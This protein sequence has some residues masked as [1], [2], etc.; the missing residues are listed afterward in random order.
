MSGT[1]SGAYELKHRGKIHRVSSFN[2]LKN[3]VS[4]SRVASEDSFRKAGSDQWISVMAEPEFALILNPENQWV[5]TM[6]S[7][8]FKTL[9]FETIVKWA[10]DGRITEDAVIEGP[11]TPPGGVSATALP[12]IASNLKKQIQN[13]QIRPVLRIDGK[14]HPAPDTETIRNWIKDSRVPVEAEIS[15]EGKAWEPVSSCGLFDLEDWPLAAHGRVVEKLLPEMPEPDEPALKEEKE[16]PEVEKKTPV[17]DQPFREILDVDAEDHSDDEKGEVP[18]IV[19][20]G[21]SEMAIES[22]AKI[23][24]LLR[25]RVIFSYDEVRHPSIAEERTSVGEFMESMM[26]S[27]RNP[28]FWI[29]WGLAGTA[30]IVAALEY[31]EVLDFFTWLP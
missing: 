22:V 19:I 13:K 6:K 28:M 18:Y 9:D 21:D 14:K 27:R 24:S 11:R 30:V 20:S 15:L 4:E 16:Q 23:K 12:A 29:L 17:T 10:K 31:F 25:K 26:P 3:W 1:A 8:V 7:G 5:I 2:E